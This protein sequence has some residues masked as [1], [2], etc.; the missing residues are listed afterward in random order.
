M[1]WKIIP[2]FAVLFL[3]LIPFAWAKQP[4]KYMPVFPFGADDFIM[5]ALTFLP[6]ITL[7]S[8]NVTLLH[9]TNTTVT[10][11]NMTGNI[12]F[13]ANNT[14]SIGDAENYAESLF[15]N[16]LNAVTGYIGTL[17]GGI[18]YEAGV[19]LTDKYIE[20]TD[21]FGGDVSGTYDNL[22]VEDTQGLSYTN[23]T[24]NPWIEDAQ[25]GD[26][27]TNASDYW[28]NLNTPP[29]IW[30]RDDYVNETGD[31][32]TGNLNM[33][34]DANTTDANSGTYTYF[35]PGGAFVVHLEAG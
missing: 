29:A 3:L 16:V 15:V 28:D 34:T 10:Y 30:S 35:R 26:L 7:P 27:N 18:I 11:I 25:E 20:L 22:L 9:V 12:T 14:Y 31:T 24:D 19:S 2:I 17:Y 5:Y 33:D 21:T 4:A 23:I 8:L 32:M 13:N 6:H 1:N